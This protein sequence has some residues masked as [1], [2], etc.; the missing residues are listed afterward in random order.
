LRMSRRS[1]TSGHGGRILRL[2]LFPG[3]P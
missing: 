1:S 2:R 3:E